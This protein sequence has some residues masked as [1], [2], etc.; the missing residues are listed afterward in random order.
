MAIGAVLSD[1]LDLLRGR[2]FREDC[3][4][5]ATTTSTTSSHQ[6]LLM[7]LIVAALHY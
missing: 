4:P 5:G 6:L 2:D 7:L 1:E 3:D